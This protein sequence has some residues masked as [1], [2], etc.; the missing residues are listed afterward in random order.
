VKTTKIIFLLLLTCLIGCAAGSVKPLLDHPDFKAENQPVRTL[1]VLLVTDDTYRKD[2]IEKWI[3]R[4]S[5]LVEVQVGIRL[6]IVGWHR[7]V[8]EKELSD[9]FRTHIRMAADTWTRRETF[10]VAVAPAYFVQR[11]GGNKLLLGAVD[12]F[13]WRYIFVKEMDPNIL[14]HELFHAFLLS[15]DHSDDWVMRAERSPYGIEW[16]WLT[17]E[18]R[19]V[20]L[21]N[22][23]RDFNVMP[24]TGRKEEQKSKESWFYY[25]LGSFFLQRRDL[26]QATFMFTQSLEIDLT[27][28]PPYNKLA[29]IH[30]TADEAAFRNG[31]EAVKLALKACELSNWDNLEYLDTLAAAYAR[32]GEFDKAIEWQEKAL[33]GMKSRE[34]REAGAL[35][36]I[37]PNENQKTSE[38]RQRLNLYRAHKP[39]P[40]N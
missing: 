39:W 34:N 30:A 9:I 33:G 29:W 1:R 26:K 17:P 14:L 23:W 40:P 8:W 35:E 25:V 15:A 31:Q 27:F 5:H 16:Y 36:P 38:L 12:T 3:A 11:L 7:I 20:I 22:K 37:K 6:E 21:R 13:F 32:A 24:V 18:Q 2:E 4:C 19:K 28:P 10:D